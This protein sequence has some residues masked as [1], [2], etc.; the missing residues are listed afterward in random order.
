MI[1]ESTSYEIRLEY[2][3]SIDDACIVI[4]H[5]NTGKVL[6]FQEYDAWIQYVGGNPQR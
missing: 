5:A 4:R 6:S 1:N 2:N 3:E